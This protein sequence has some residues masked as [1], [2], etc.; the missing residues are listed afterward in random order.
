[1]TNIHKTKDFPEFKPLFKAMGYRKKSFILN[2][3][4]AG[5]RETGPAWWDGGSRTQYFIADRRANVSPAACI[6]NPFEFDRDVGY[7]TVTIDDNSAMVTDG[8]FCGKPSVLKIY[9]TEAWLN[10]QGA[11][12]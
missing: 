6:S 10:N 4:E 12:L 9:A 3:V 5:E 7:P 11:L 8:I 1:M 2:I